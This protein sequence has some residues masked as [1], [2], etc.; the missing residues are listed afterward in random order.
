MSQHILT[1]DEIRQ[2][3]DDERRDLIHRLQRPLDEIGPGHM[4]IRRLRRTRIGLM[5]G[6]AVGLIP[7]IVFL[8]LTLPTEYIAH[9]WVI[10][11]VGFDILLVVLMAATAVLGWLRRQ[12]LVLTG[13]AT[14]VLL[15]CDAWFDVMTASPADRWVSLLTAFLA[16][17]PLAA[18]LIIGTVRIM[19]LGAVRL[20]MLEPSAP[21]WR[22]RVTVVHEP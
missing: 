8:A 21:L 1:D 12:L 6:G 16:E 9:N 10:T 17:L 2:M 13:F 7:W 15:V 5:A 3:T 4:A 22:L 19:R 14:G 11:W 20:W 18:L